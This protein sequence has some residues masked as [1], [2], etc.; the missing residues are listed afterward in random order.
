MLPALFYTNNE[1]D[2]SSICSLYKAY[3]VLVNDL[4][5]SAYW[6]RIRTCCVLLCCAVAL[7]LSADRRDARGPERVL[8]VRCRVRGATASGGGWQ[9]RAILSYPIQ[10]E[11][12]RVALHDSLI[13]V[14]VQ[15]FPITNNRS[16]PLYLDGAIKFASLVAPLTDLDSHLAAKFRGARLSVDPSFSILHAALL[17]SYRT[18]HYT[19]AGLFTTSTVF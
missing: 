6:F 14:R 9:V 2:M 10:S 8:H 19:R 4:I 17:V 1:I 5:T 15:V 16:T 3:N 7:V 13:N 18:V 12:K 11:S